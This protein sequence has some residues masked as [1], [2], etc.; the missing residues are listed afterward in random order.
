[1][2]LPSLEILKNRVRVVRLKGTNLEDLADTFHD[3][4]RRSAA[5]AFFMV[6]DF[7]GIPDCPAP[8]VQA[9]LNF[10][11]DMAAQ[12]G[13]LF[14]C[15]LSPALVDVIEQNI[16]TFATVH[17]ALANCQMQETNV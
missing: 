8:I 5:N 6:I 17:E 4:L 9:L 7:T 3:F 10:K 15:G 13:T 11:L 12:D 1:M 16:R 2:H 14:A